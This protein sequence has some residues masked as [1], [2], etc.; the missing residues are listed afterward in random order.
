MKDGA[1]AVA[2][3][4]DSQLL[5]AI[6]GTGHATVWNLES[7]SVQWSGSAHSGYGSDIVFSPDGA[8]LATSG[9]DRRV[10]LWNA[11]NGDAIATLPAAKLPVYDIAFSPDGSRIAGVTVTGSDLAQPGTLIIWDVENKK[12]LRKYL[13]HKGGILCAAISPDGQQIATGSYDR[14]VR[15]WKMP[16]LDA[17]DE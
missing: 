7:K 2:F 13:G 10:K 15:L 1:F 12:I 14:S 11:V 9:A 8:L 5:A 4:P 16:P 3:S 17:D 6:D